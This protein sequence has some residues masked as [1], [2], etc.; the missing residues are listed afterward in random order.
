MRRAPAVGLLLAGSV[1]GL[2]ACTS[3]GRDA[4]DAPGPCRAGLRRHDVR[5]GPRPRA[6]RAARQ[7]ARPPGGRRRLRRLVARPARRL[8]P[9]GARGLALHGVRRGAPGRRGRQQALPGRGRRPA[10]GRTRAFAARLD[11]PGGRR[12]RRTAGTAA[13]LRSP[14]PGCGSSRPRACGCSTPTGSATDPVLRV[15]RLGDGVR[16]STLAATGR[17]ARH[18]RLPAERSRSRP[19]VRRVGPAARR[20]HRPRGG[21]CRP[22]EVAMERSTRV[23]ATPPGPGVHPGRRAVVRL[24][25]ASPAGS[26]APVAGRATS[27]PA[28]RTW[29]STGAPS[30]RSARPAR[31]RTATRAG[32]SCRGCCSS[33]GRPSRPAV[34]R[35]ASPE[36]GIVADRAGAPACPP[37]KATLASLP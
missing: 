6:G 1:L 19:L 27:C 20:R 32:P 7:P 28:R 24:V 25:A 23:P 15:W 37:G 12:D 2:G 29:W 26:S 31:R 11:P 35:P 4:A 30:G 36:P 8:R 3:D 9:A 10:V 17:Q 22:G 18:R 21:G 34:R 13:A 14:T 33:T 16:G 5:R